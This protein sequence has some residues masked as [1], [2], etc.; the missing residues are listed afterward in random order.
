M[1]SELQKCDAG[2]V[3]VNRPKA[4]DIEN[5]LIQAMEKGPDIVERMMAVRR[6]LNAEQAKAAFD[7]AIRDFQA[8]VPPIKKTRKVEGLYNSAPF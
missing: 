2:A 7:Q 8:E 4:V 3:D 1:K 6:E 5:L